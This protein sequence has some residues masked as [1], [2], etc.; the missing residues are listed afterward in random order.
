[1]AKVLVIRGGAIGDFVLTLPVLQL[2]RENLPGV[3]LEVLGYKPI[4]A[5]AEKAGLADATRSI[6]HR[7]LAMFFIPN[8]TLDPEWSSW[9]A[10]FN[11]II[12]YLW[13][14]D[15]HFGKNLERV[16]VKTLLVG[17]PKP[18]APG[19]HASAQLAK[20]LEK[21]ALFWDEN[22]VASSRF[23]E[24]TAKPYEVSQRIALHPGSGGIS[25]N[26]PVEYWISLGE[27]LAKAH[28]ACQ[29][30]LVTGEAEQE[31]GTTT[32]IKNAWSGINW[33]HFDSLPLTELA[34]QLA[35]CDLFVGHDSGISHLAAAC[36]TPCLLLFGP[37]DPRVWAPPQQ[38]VTALQQEDRDLS[39]ISVAEVGEKIDGILNGT[40]GLAGQ[41]FL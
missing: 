14:E 10:S 9:F 36:G 28:P 22:L 4:I 23:F 31:R 40:R 2:L 35:L 16:G 37:T 6:E 1:M 32:R 5:L 8:A 3:H 24:R 41:S 30:C 39:A 12:S 19:P 7:P 38:W 25:K 33:E 15:G 29:L 21:V 20:P 18:V 17:P 26:W 11:M 27:M 34:G 13:D